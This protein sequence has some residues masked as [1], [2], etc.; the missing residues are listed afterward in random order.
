MLSLHVCR[1]RRLRRGSVRRSHVGNGPTA[2]ATESKVPVRGERVMKTAQPKPKP[3]QQPP[4]PRHWALPVL[5]LLLA[6]G[7]SWATFELVVWN[8][9]PADLVG[10]WVVEGGSQ[11]GAT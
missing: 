11:D 4:H 3:P 10:K 8:K 5:L 6:G 9:L 1:V 2:R 7:G